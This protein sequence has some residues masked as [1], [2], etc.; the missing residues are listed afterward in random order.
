MEYVFQKK[1][2]INYHI[3]IQATAGRGSKTFLWD[4]KPPK[5]LTLKIHAFL[6][7]HSGSSRPLKFT[8]N[9]PGSPRITQDHPVPPRVT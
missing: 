8:Q 5:R 7:G 2:I 3:I 9:L 4:Y 6:Q 1:E